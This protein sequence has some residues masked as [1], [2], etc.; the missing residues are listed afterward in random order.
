MTIRCV[1][2]EPVVEHLSDKPHARVLIDQVR[3]IDVRYVVGH[4]VDH[5]TRDDLMDVE[6][7]LAH[8]L[9]VQDATPPRLA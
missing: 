7:A 6:L 2:A 5:L 1:K 4:P 3:S 8:Y 9:G